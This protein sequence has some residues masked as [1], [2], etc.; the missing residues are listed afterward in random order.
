VNDEVGWDWAKEQLQAGAIDIERLHEEAAKLLPGYQEKADRQANERDA[1]LSLLRDAK[2]HGD[3]FRFSRADRNLGSP[4]DRTLATVI[5]NCTKAEMTARPYVSIM[6]DVDSL[7]MAVNSVLETLRRANCATV[8]S[9]KIF[10]R[11]RALLAD[12]VELRNLRTWVP[13]CGMLA[14][15]LREEDDLAGEIAKQ[16]ADT[17]RQH[18]PE[19]QYLHYILPHSR[20]E[21][22][23]NFV[24]I[25]FGIAGLVS[26]DR[27][28]AISLLP[29][30]LR[31][32]VTTAKQLGWLPEDYLGERWP[33]Y[34][35]VG[36]A[37]SRRTKREAMLRALEGMLRARQ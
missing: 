21:M 5:L 24:E 9:D 8:S 14:C 7:M 10:A 30:G 28:A 23:T 26:G 35:T 2:N 32:V 19:V 29:F 37:E 36:S 3:A 1:A 4:A 17:I 18:S 20:M 13:T 11:T 16:L 12:P 15:H 31:P 25:W 6:P 34:V 22:F 27:T 33:F